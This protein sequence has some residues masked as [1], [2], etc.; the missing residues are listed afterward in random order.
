MTYKC[1]FLIFFLNAKRL[2]YSRLENSSMKI[3]N[4]FLI[5][6]NLILFAAYKMIMLV[7]NAADFADWR[8]FYFAILYFGSSNSVL[9]NNKWLIFVLNTLTNECSNQLTW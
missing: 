8:K 6:F 7:V 9:K 3:I 2:I 4:I 1:M 5:G